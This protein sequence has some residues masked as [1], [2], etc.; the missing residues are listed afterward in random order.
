MLNHQKLI[1]LLSA[2]CGMIVCCCLMSS[3]SKDYTAVYYMFRYDWPEV[4]IQPRDIP[5]QYVREKYEQILNEITNLNCNESTYWEV[6]ILNDN[7]K[8]E[9]Q[10]AKD[11]FN[12][13]LPE[14]MRVEDKCK[15]IINDMEIREGLSFIIE[16]HCK[17]ERW[18]P[19][20]D[21]TVTLQEYIFKLK[22]N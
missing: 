8:A 21:T 18:M 20:Y 15:E 9:D 12:R 14:L 7:Y 1:H 16:F 19:V 4:P 3:C 2:F 22:Y 17:L 10:K 6:E 5:D 13:F 11:K